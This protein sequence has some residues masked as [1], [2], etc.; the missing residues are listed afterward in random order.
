MKRNLWIP[1]MLALAIVIGCTRR[2]TPAPAL[3]AV[4]AGS[5]L[6]ESSGG[7]QLGTPGT[8][9]PQP[10]VAQVNDQH[11]NTV[12]GALVRFSGSGGMTFDPAEG[13][14]DS[15]GQ[16]STNVTLGDTA[17]RYE[18]T[19]TS[20]DKSGKLFV[21]TSAELAAGYQQQLGYELNE[22][23]CARCHDPESSPERVSN[24]D[25]LAVKPHAFT[26]GEMLNKMSTA[27]LTAVI[28]HGGPA[29]NGSALMPPYGSTLSKAE[30]QALIAYIRLVSDPP[31]RV[32][33]VVYA[34]R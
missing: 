5:A 11:G 26:E 17:G 10:F 19:A 23:Y 15:S 21:L 24:Y 27:D 8:Q 2:S 28:S 31:Y 30:I 22:N 25:N 20:P 7:K 32:S 29:L 12:T 4:A 18:M 9:L 16:I 13:L 1:A 3:H 14:T 34:K 6:V 33:G